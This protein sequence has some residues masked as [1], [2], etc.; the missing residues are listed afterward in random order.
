MS[1]REVERPALFVL[2]YEGNCYGEGL[3]EKTM[4]RFIELLREKHP[5]VPILVV[6]VIP[7]ASMR[8]SE[9][10]RRSTKERME[11]QKSIVM[12]KRDAG[13]ENIYFH[14]GRNLLG[15]D[16]EECTVDGVHP[17]DLGFWHMAQVLE[18]VIRN[19]IF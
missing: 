10:T 16:F 6:S 1:V 7:F 17:T 14:D 2:D 8:F 19:I 3:L 12:E 15:D 5:V 9:G 18:P 4:R 11:L 13:D